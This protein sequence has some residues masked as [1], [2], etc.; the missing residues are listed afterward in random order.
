ME[1]GVEGEGLGRGQVGFEKVGDKPTHIA[2]CE[3]TLCCS[4]EDGIPGKINLEE[5]TRRNCIM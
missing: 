3:M 4:K 1:K 5:S 2:C